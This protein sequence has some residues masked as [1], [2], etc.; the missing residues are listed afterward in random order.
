MCLIP[1]PANLKTMFKASSLFLLPDLFL[2]KASRTFHFVANPM[3]KNALPKRRKSAFPSHYLHNATVKREARESTTQAIANFLQQQQLLDRVANGSPSQV[4][5]AFMSLPEDAQLDRKQWQRLTSVLEQVKTKLT[6]LTA[7]E[8]H[9]FSEALAHKMPQDG[10]SWKETVAQMRALSAANRGFGAVQ[11]LHVRSPFISPILDLKLWV[12]IVRAFAVGTGS[13]QSVLQTLTKLNLDGVYGGIAKTALALYY[14]R[15]GRIEAM[16]SILTQM[17]RDGIEPLPEA[18]AE[19]TSPVPGPLPL[20][21]I[22]NPNR[23]PMAK[24]VENVNSQ[25]QERLIRGELQGVQSLFW[26]M[27]LDGIAPNAQTFNLIIRSKLMM[28]DQSV[29]GLKDVSKMVEKVIKQSLN[30][31]NQDF[32]NVDRH[33]QDE[34]TLSEETMQDL[35]VAFAKHKLHRQARCLLTFA[36]TR[37]NGAVT[38]DMVLL[39]VSSHVQFPPPYVPFV[40]HR[41]LQAERRERVHIA[42]EILVGASKLGC[43]NMNDE[44]VMQY[45]LEIY[46]QWPDT[47]TYNQIYSKYRVLGHSMTEAVYTSKMLLYLNQ[48]IPFLKNAIKVY[49][50]MRQSGIIPKSKEALVIG[51]YLLALSPNH[52]DTKRITNDIREFCGSTPLVLARAEMTNANAMLNLAEMERIVDEWET[53][54]PP[55]MSLYV[56]WL[57]GCHLVKDVGAALDVFVRMM[58]CNLQ[59]TAKLYGELLHALSHAA[60]TPPRFNVLDKELASLPGKNDG[61]NADGRF[62]QVW[63]EVMKMQRQSNPITDLIYNVILPDLERRNVRLSTHLFLHLAAV[64]ARI[65][66]TDEAE[67]IWNC[68]NDAGLFNNRDIIYRAQTVLMMIRKNRLDVDGLK[69]LLIHMPSGY[70]PRDLHYGMLLHLVGSQHGPMTAQ[71]LLTKVPRDQSNFARLSLIKTFAKE[72]QAETALKMLEDWFHEGEDVKTW[73]LLMFAKLEIL[74]KKCDVVKAFDCY[75]VLLKQGCVMDPLIMQHML[76]M[77]STNENTKDL[78]ALLKDMERNGIRRDLSHVLQIVTIYASRRHHAKAVQIYL[79]CRM[80][81]WRPVT[82]QFVYATRLLFRRLVHSIHQLRDGDKSSVGYQ[83]SNQRLASWETVVPSPDAIELQIDQDWQEL[84]PII[85]S[86]VEQAGLSWVDIGKN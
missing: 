9:E 43:V 65:G 70:T 14:H 27:I 40:K 71:E 45:L 78:F 36:M 73:R 85:Q 67:L 7:R 53:H 44:K 34:F 76:N 54:S 83:E 39:A 58:S 35:L 28:P 19:I 23:K 30:T 84:L 63:N 16:N 13:A 2:P 31:P 21:K 46:R 47:L 51:Q 52:P 18:L 82:S 50:E 1:K 66:E 55:E 56:H 3:P 11:L 10:A 15:I 33:A 49:D 72:Y 61:V 59:P 17:R 24:D 74:A 12:D 32:F 20:R 6:D 25:M 5:R 41:Q 79:L 48:K 77:V 22:A 37:W 29:Q 4:V 57:R 80:P 64:H 8:V 86:D 38:Q 26:D 75:H 68:C 42:K 69:H 60:Y 81:G 62:D